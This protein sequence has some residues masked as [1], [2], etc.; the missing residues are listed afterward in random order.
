[1]SLGEIVCVLLALT[2]IGLLYIGYRQT[3]GT[4]PKNSSFG[5]RTRATTAS[6]K[7]WVAGNRAAAS[8][9]YIQG[10]ICI[11]CGAAGFAVY[12][13]TSPLYL[14]FGGF[15]VIA[16]FGISGFQVVRANR[17]AQHAD[18]ENTP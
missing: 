13:P 18:D 10:A 16:I 6:P 12:S 5:T 7:A 15:A 14:V 1:M 11:I 8:L 4:L 2:G 3:N 17:A 9:S